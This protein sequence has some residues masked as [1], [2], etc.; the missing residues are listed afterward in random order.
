MA[1][2]TFDLG[3]MADAPWE[4]ALLVPSG[5]I[6]GGAVAYLRYF[7]PVGSLT[8]QM[9][10]ASS[11]TADPLLPG[12]KFTAAVEGYV[13]ALTFDDDGGQDSITLPGPTNPTNAF[14]DPTEPYT[15]Q[16]PAGSP[17]LS[18]WVLAAGVVILTITDG[19]TD[20]LSL[21]SSRAC[22]GTNSGRY[23]QRW[24]LCNRRQALGSLN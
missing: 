17:N 13:A 14:T 3:V 10:L 11:P 9:R 22:P 4:G 16:V 2:G 23:G 24:R 7:D 20:S 19:G 1:E 8:V 15:W 5:L 6:E 18:D 12:P 21:L